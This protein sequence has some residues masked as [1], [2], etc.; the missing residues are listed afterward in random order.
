[1]LNIIPIVTTKK[2]AVEYC[3]IYRKGNEKY[4]HF[5]ANIWLTTKESTNVGSHGQKPMRYIENTLQ[6]SRIKSLSV[7]TLNVNRLS[8]AVIGRHKRSVHLG[9]GT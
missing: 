6:N 7:V 8:Y 1:M 3:R 9:L 4:K 5:T 2:I